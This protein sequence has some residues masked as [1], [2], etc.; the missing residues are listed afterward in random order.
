MKNDFK[1]NELVYH[2]KNDSMYLIEEIEIL[3]NIKIYYLNNFKTNRTCSGFEFL[4]CYNDCIKFLG[5]K[6]HTKWERF[7]VENGFCKTGTKS[8]LKFL[9]QETS[10]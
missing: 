8:T 4:L 7:E 3:D 2:I 9:I 1:I 6:G 5:T 10:K